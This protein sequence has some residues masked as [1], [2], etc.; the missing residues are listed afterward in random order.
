MRTST[1]QR[2]QQHVYHTIQQPAMEKG[3][4]SMNHLKS[5]MFNR[6]KE[7]DFTDDKCPLLQRRYSEVRRS[8]SLAALA[9]AYQRM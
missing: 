9:L 1:Q 3:A 7:Q 6:N 8:W 5:V 4:E 2:L